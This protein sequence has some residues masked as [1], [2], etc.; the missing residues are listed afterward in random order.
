MQKKENIPFTVK[1]TGS[2]GDGGMVK[3][4]GTHFNINGYGDEGLIITTLLE[5]SVLVEKNGLS[6]I[7]KPGEQA[8]SA[9]NIAVVKTDVNE[10]IAWKNGRFLFRNATIKSIGEQI[11]RWYDVEVVYGGNIP[12]HFNT[13]MSRNLPLSKLLDG[14]EGT[15]QVHFSLDGRK[16]TIK[17]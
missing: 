6:K 17:P 4:L 11:K 2:E 12:Q 3:V 13:E 7:L 8:L 9:K 1:I 5:G 14:L 15:M 10:A 16:L